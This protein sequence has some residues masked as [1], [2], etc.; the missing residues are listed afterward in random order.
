MALSLIF[1]E[2]S[3]IVLIHVRICVYWRGFSFPLYLICNDE[4]RVPDLCSR[5]MIVY[6]ANLPV[7]FLGCIEADFCNEVLILHHFSKYIRS[8]H[9][10]TA[11]IPNLSTVQ[12]VTAKNVAAAAPDVRP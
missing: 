2:R 3:S 6:T 4:K 11:Q 1:S 8:A 10:C 7:P 5:A 9:F 12:A